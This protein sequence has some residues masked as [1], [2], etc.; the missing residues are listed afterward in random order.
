MT[1]FRVIVVLVGGLALL[2]VVVILRAETTRLHYSIARCERDA[3]E[4][5]QQLVE[6]ELELARLRNPTRIRQ[7]I[8]QAVAQPAEEPAPAPPPRRRARP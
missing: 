3:D 2:L 6:A 1:L 8:E 4:M 7:R 5:R